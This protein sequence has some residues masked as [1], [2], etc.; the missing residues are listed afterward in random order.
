MTTI[1]EDIVDS[2]WREVASFRSRDAWRAMEKVT[3]RQPALLAYVMAETRDCGSDAQELA[4]YLFFVVLRMFDRLPGHRLKR[5]TIE[6]VERHAA[7]NEAML[8]RLGSAHE[9]FLERAAQV[10]AET[11]PHVFRYLTEAILE[12]DDPELEL[13]EEESGL[14]F[15]VLKTVVDLLDR[16]CKKQRR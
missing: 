16:A 10:Q 2:T 9:R 12:G 8:E 13:T 4:I 6:Q 11:Q 14:L 15:L 5:V 1:S 3:K 7:E